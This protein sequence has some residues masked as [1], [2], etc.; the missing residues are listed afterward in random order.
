[1]EKTTIKIN[2]GDYRISFGVMQ[3]IKYCKLRNITITEMNEEF[4]KYETGNTDGS[5]FVDLLWSALSDGA[6][7]DKKKFLFTNEDVGDFIDDIEPGEIEKFMA[8]LI[9][10][11]PENKK[12]ATKKVK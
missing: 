11:L 2:N 3:T 8:T 5:E 9:K 10:T 6:R 12:K 7:R 4:A 1:M